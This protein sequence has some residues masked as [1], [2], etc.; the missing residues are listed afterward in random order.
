MKLPDGSVRLVQPPWAGKLSG[1]TQLFEALVLC[2]CRDL[3]AAGR[4]GN[5]DCREKWTL[6]IGQCV[7]WFLALCHHSIGGSVVHLIG[8]LFIQGLMPA[9]LVVKPK[10]THQ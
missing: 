2:L 5:G 4:P 3:P 1:F 8:R 9:S 6:V 10:I 7:K